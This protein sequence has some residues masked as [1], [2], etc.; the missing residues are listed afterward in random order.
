M[1]QPDDVLSLTGEFRRWIEAGVGGEAS[2]IIDGAAF[3]AVVMPLRTGRG[4]TASQTFA[5]ASAGRN[6][7]VS[8]SRA[9]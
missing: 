5:V 1:V 4:A 3:R 2:G 9:Q 8:E 6:D 7:G